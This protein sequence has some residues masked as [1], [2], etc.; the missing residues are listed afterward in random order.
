MGL[1]SGFIQGAAAEGVKVFGSAMLKE[2]EMQKAKQIAAYSAELADTA[3]LT[4]RARDVEGEE[5]TYQKG[6]LRAPEIR[7]S[8][9][10][11]TIATETAKLDPGVTEAGIARKTAEAKST[12]QLMIDDAIAKGGNKDYLKALSATAAATRD[13]VAQATAQVQLEVARL[14]LGKVKGELADTAELKGLI[15]SRNAASQGGADAAGVAAIDAQI[16][17]KKNVISGASPDD[18]LKIQTTAVKLAEEGKKLRESG[19]EA[20]ATVFENAA[21]ELLQ[22]AKVSQGGG[23]AS[24]SV[25]PPVADRVVGKVYDTPKG[26]MEWV[27]EG[28]WKPPSA[29]GTD[30]TSNVSSSELISNARDFVDTSDKISALRANLE[31]SPNRAAS[32][33]RIAELEKRIAKLDGW[34]REKA[35][36]VLSANARR[37]APESRKSIMGGE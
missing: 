37:F 33:Q 21:Q 30:E 24:G 28:K 35:N 6:L 26:K 5:A 16:A 19:N 8:K 2:L 36:D 1:M 18:A 7:A 23:A 25:L 22:R 14:N 11:D 34:T 20:G 9:A 10:A 32:A 17:G 31:G 13:P 15:S 12:S 4:K 3:D 29:R 27:G